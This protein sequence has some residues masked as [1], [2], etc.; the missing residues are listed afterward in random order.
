MIQGLLSLLGNDINVLNVMLLSLLSLY[1]QI[2][3]MVLLIH[4]K[5]ANLSVY[6]LFSLPHLIL[7]PKLLYNAQIFI[8]LHFLPT[9][10]IIQGYLHS[11][12]YI[13]LLF[14]DKECNDFGHFLSFLTHFLYFML[15]SLASIFHLKSILPDPI[16]KLI[17]FVLSQF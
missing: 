5:I 9:Y 13:F 2:I 10:Q 15:M 11:L 4:N 8:I 17:H 6:K 16:A 7:L 14:Y 1:G 12:Q 3:Y